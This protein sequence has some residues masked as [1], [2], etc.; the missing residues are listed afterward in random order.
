MLSSPS[1]FIE[2]QAGVRRIGKDDRRAWRHVER[3]RADV[4]TNARTAA[5]SGTASK[6]I[7]QRQRLAPL[8]FLKGFPCHS[9]DHIAFSG[10]AQFPGVRAGWRGEDLGRNRILLILGQYDDFFQSLLQ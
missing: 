2:L 6:Q 3:R 5:W 1:S 8:V 4:K 7:V 9:T 10:K